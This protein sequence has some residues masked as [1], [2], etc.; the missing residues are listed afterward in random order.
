M[1]Q[2]RAKSGA[3]TR[4][5]RG[6]REEPTGAYAVVREDRRR[7]RTKRGDAYRRRSYAFDDAFAED[8]VR[9]N[10]QRQDHQDVRREILGAAAHV[11]VDVPGGHVLHDADDEPADD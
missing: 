2:L 4:A 5:A 10:H 9:A 3:E 1:L 8:T 7:P 6:P 11:R